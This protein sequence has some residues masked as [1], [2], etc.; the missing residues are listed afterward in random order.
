MNFNQVLSGR[1]AIR[2]YTK[3]TVDAKSI[4]HLIDC[5]VMAPNAVNQ[6]PWA[7]IV[8]SDKELLDKI[9]EETKNHVK[10]EKHETRHV[11]NFHTNLTDPASHIFYHA[12]VLILISAIEAGPW[13]VQDCALAAENL[14]L[15]AYD[16][17]LGSCWIGF[18]QSFLSS[19]RGRSL[20]Q[21]PDGWVPVAP[22]IVGHT[23]HFPEPTPRNEPVIRWIG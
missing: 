9:S 16:Q 18:A 11:G 13:I 15:S 14:M 8:V 17:G 4:R 5:A 6:Q 1:R 2:E 10:T 7:F 19:A 12:P 21:M 20:V 23:T 3:Q 22:V